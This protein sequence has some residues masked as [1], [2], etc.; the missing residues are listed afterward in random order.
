MKSGLP[1]HY[2]KLAALLFLLECGAAWPDV[3]P[4]AAMPEQ[5]SRALSEEIPA[6]TQRAA[7]LIEKE[8]E[9]AKSPLGEEAKKIKFVLNDIVLVGNHVYPKSVLEPLYKDKLHKEISVAELFDIV[10]S[11]TNY[12]RNNGYIISRAILPPQHVKNGVVKVQVIE[13]FI[14]QITVGG[15]P[16][17]AKCMVEIYGKKIKSQPPLQ[18]TRMEKYLLLAN[19]IPATQV[20]AVMGP[21]KTTSGAADLTLMTKNSPITAYF[22]YDNY[23]TRYIGPQQMTGNFAL[24]SFFN[25]GDSG[26]VTMTKTPK[27]GELTYFDL[28]YATPITDEGSRLLL[29][30]TRTHTHPLFVLRPAQIDGYMTT[31]MVTQLFP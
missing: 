23:G 6:A 17:G 15:E 24:N 2:A 28:N 14:D 9:K 19:E 4:G 8:K 10:Q 22:S 30:G 31:T 18:I 27:G 26:N 25:T 20:K 11:I 1:F 29:G 3:L 7:P 5:V 12:Y 16:H 21:S 13:G